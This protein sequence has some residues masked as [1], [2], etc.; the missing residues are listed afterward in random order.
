[1]WSANNG[2]AQCKLA[3][4]IYA[5]DGTTYTIDGFAMEA[6][7]T[8][9][10]KTAQHGADNN[11]NAPEY[12]SKAWMY[13]QLVFWKV[14]D[15]QRRKDYYE[16]SELMNLLSTIREPKPVGVSPGVRSVKVFNSI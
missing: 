13:A 9:S 8:I 5:Y 4:S 1:M 16:R 6:R 15:G 7:S 11:T 3:K 2:V 12:L 14:L 10:T